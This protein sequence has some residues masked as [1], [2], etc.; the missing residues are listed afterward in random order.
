MYKK[1][2]DGIDILTSSGSGNLG[3]LLTTG[4]IMLDSLQTVLVRTRLGLTNGCGGADDESLFLTEVLGDRISLGSI[5]P[6]LS[7]LLG[8]LT[9]ENPVGFGSTS[10]YAGGGVSDLGGG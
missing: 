7:E 3:S 6:G 2:I 10:E 4:D 8:G 5:L 9:G 1:W